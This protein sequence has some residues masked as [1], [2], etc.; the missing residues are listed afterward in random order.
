MC[1]FMFEYRNDFRFIL[2]HSDSPKQ[3]TLSFMMDENVYNIV[4]NVVPAEEK[5]SHGL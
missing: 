4:Y 3:Q 1:M 2:I 5:S